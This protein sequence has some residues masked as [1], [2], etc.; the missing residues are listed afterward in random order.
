VPSKSKAMAALG[1]VFLGI[2]YPLF[3]N[4]GYFLKL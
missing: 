3:N 1:F 4:L 2:A